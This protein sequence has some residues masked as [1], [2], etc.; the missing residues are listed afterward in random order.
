MLLQLRSPKRPPAGP[1]GFGGSRL[2]QMGLLLDKRA[3]GLL[4]RPSLKEVL[5]WAKSLEALLTDQCKTVN[6]A[7]C[8]VSSLTGNHG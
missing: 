5:R 1:S 2:F 4:L 8:G 3:L 7:R 6:F